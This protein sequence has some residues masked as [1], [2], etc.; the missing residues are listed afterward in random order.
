MGVGEL[1]RSNDSSRGEEGGDGDDDDD[2][3]DDEDDDDEKGDKV[4]G[5]CRSG[6]DNENRGGVGGGAYNESNKSSV[7]VEGVE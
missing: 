2:D 4:G 3:E 6:R 5:R 7:I 1:S